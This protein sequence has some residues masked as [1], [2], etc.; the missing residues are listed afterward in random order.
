[1]ND[2]DLQCSISTA[3]S[4]RLC[5]YWPIAVLLHGIHLNSNAHPTSDQP[6]YCNTTFTLKLG[7]WGAILFL[8]Y[9]YCTHVS[10]DVSAT[11]TAI[12]QYFVL[13]NII[14]HCTVI[15]PLYRY[16]KGDSL[17]RVLRDGPKIL[18]F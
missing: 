1:M 3:L 18:E 11:N 9:R 6:P 15:S 4:V 8:P 12:I 2:T 10:C 7:S 17:F 13:Y 5:G 16:A 14:S